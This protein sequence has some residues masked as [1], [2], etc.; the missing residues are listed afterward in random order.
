MW[1]HRRPR[2]P[3]TTGGRARRLRMAAAAIPT[4][5]PA[6]YAPPPPQAQS[7]SDFIIYPK[8]GQSKDQQAADQYEC[9]NWAKGQTG[10]DPTQPNGGV[11]AGEADRA[12]SNY[13]RAMAA[14]LQGRG[15]QVN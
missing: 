4:P 14:C 12:H 3:R 10:F 2:T 9:N 13:D 15:Y 1:S 5:H 8:Q 11:A 7:P 6:V